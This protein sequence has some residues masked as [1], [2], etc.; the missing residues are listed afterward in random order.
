MLSQDRQS[1]GALVQYNM[2]NE[3]FVFL[4]YEWRVLKSKDESLLDV[5]TYRSIVGVCIRYIDDGI[6]L[7]GFEEAEESI[8]WRNSF[9]ISDRTACSSAENS[10]QADSIG[11]RATFRPRN[12]IIPRPFFILMTSIDTVPCPARMTVIREAHTNQ[13]QPYHIP[14]Y[15]RRA[16]NLFQNEDIF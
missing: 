1:G 7:G 12:D 3:I 10:S 4:F 14:R 9:G 15:S 5:S 11:N 8:A 13:A 6:W 16:P 2:M